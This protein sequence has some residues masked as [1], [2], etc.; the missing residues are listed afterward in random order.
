MGGKDKQAIGMVRVKVRSVIASVIL[1]VA[2]VAVSA[3]AAQAASASP[4]TLTVN[5]CQF[6]STGTWDQ[7]FTGQVGD[8]FQIINSDSASCALKVSTGVSTNAG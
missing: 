1:G 7:T 5:D 8:T 6:S 2:A 4:A 3:P